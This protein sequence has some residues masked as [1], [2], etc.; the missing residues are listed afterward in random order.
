[1][2]PSKFFL[3]VTAL[4]ALVS[5]QDTRPL[6]AGDAIAPRL[7]SYVPRDATPSSSGATAGTQKLKVACYRLW[8]Q[9]TR[10]NDCCPGLF[11]RLGNGN[12]H[13]DYK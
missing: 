7:V 9:C 3:L 6:L 1:V 11:C 12:A 13:C 5:V 2:K 8:F 4:A 10:E